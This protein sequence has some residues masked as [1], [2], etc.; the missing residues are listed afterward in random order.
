MM[1]ALAA[2][3]P[4]DGRAAATFDDRTDP[5]LGFGKGRSPCCGQ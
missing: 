2:Q 3:K 4:S 1:D 5:N